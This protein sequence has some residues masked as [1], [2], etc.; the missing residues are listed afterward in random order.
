MMYGPD[1]KLFELAP[2]GAALALS[3]SSSSKSRARPER[4]VAGCW[5][6]Q[7]HRSS[8]S[9][10]VTPRLPA[11]GPAF[12]RF[13]RPAFGA[14]RSGSICCSQS[15]PPGRCSCRARDRSGCGWSLTLFVVATGSI[16]LCAMLARCL[17]L[18]IAAGRIGEGIWHD[19]VSLFL[20]TCLVVIIAYTGV[21]IAHHGWNLLPVFSATWRGCVGPASSISTS[22]ASCC[23]PAS[24]PRGGGI[25][26][27]HRSCWA[28]SRFLAGCCSCHSISCG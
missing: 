3:P 23:S 8:R 27:R 12:G 13:I 20:A 4:A 7:R 22:F 2:I 15:A 26:A 18:A 25:S 24:G 10:A 11:A 5:R 16:G 14:I 21:T 1:H 19:L 28:S 6:R 17:Y 9:G